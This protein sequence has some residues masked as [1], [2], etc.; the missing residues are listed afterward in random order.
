[1]ST[2]LDYLDT[3]SWIRPNQSL[4]FLIIAARVAEKQHI[5]NL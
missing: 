3:L 2:H 5:A 1:M 4:F